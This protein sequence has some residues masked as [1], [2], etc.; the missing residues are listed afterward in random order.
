MPSNIPI[1]A[2]FNAPL[3]GFRFGVFF[4]GI[5]GVDHP[6]DFRFQSVS[7]LSVE[8]Q[9]GNISG[10]DG[11]LDAGKYP[12]SRSFTN[13]VLKRGMPMASTLRVEIQESFENF[14]FTPRNVLVSILDETAIPINSWIFQ[15]AY[16]VKWS[17]ADFDATSSSVVIEEIHLAY[18]SF[19][20]MS[21]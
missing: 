10:S 15:G 19:K 20:S 16:P 1:P 13:L 17:L 8:V 21:L 5:A 12:I 6:L 11:T 14:Q 18:T 7:G 2:S 9:T 3:L 4:M